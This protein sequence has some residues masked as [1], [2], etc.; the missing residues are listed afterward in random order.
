MSLKERGDG[1][2]HRPEEVS[3]QE[4][5]EAHKRAKQVEPLAGPS[6][7][8][9]LLEGLVEEA[10]LRIKRFL[11]KKEID[12]EPSEIIHQAQVE[13]DKIK[14]KL[15]PVTDKITDK[16]KNEVG[17]H[18]D[19][20]EA[21]RRQAGG[22]SLSKA[23]ERSLTAQGRQEVE[24]A[25]ETVRGIVRESKGLLQRFKASRKKRI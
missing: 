5:M 13:A 18:V 8:T 3:V 17:K 7:A 19:L 22:E 2:L 4:A 20:Q 10:R 25:A 11:R 24:K 16:I 23:L 9:A 14:D 1:R 6:G 15:G 21:L 12:I